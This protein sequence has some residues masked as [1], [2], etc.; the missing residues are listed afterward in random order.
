MEPIINEF[1]EVISESTFCPP[2]VPII[3][4]VSSQ[5]LTDADSIKEEL[6]KQLQHCIQWQPSIEYMIRNGVISF[7]EIGP[8]K[9]LGGLIK[10]INSEVVTF[11]ISGIE[12]IAQLENSTTSG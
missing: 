10:R 3:S 2:D 8:G 7:Y 6:L 9:V 12:D 1:S 5:P 4:N 11:N